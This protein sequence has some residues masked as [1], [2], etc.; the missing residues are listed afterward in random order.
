MTVPYG[1]LRCKDGDLAVV[2]DDTS[3]CRQNL[4]RV[5]RVRGP[6]RKIKQS[7]MLGWR[8]NPLHPTPWGVTELDGRSVTELVTWDSCVYHEDAWLM[9]IRPQSADEVWREVQQEIDQS[10]IEMGAVVPLDV[11]RTLPQGPMKASKQ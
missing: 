1:A 9:P 6:V 11:T 8:I 3:D 7:G 5:V 2:I 10:L 4:G